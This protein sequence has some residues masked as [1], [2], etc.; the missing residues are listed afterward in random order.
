MIALATQ[1]LLGD[2]YR[3]DK[4]KTFKPHHISSTSFKISF[5]NE[6]PLIAHMCKVANLSPEPIK[7]LIPPYGEVNTDDIVDKSLS[8]T[9]VQ[10]E[11]SSSPRVT[12]TP[13]AEERVATADAT[14]SIDAFKLVEK[15]G[16]QQ[17]QLMLKR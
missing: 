5:E 9:N 11:S 12:D 17:S 1:H 13:S 4:L 10:P 8:G 6:V 15:L 16:N 14:Q 3:N 7:S 2:A